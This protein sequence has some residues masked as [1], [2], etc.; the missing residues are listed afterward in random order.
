MLLWLWGRP[1]AVALIGPLAW[2]P[3]WAADA[4]L[5]SKR[6][7]PKLLTFWRE[8]TWTGLSLGDVLMEGFIR[9][10]PNLPPQADWGRSPGQELQVSPSHAL[11]HRIPA[12][13]TKGGPGYRTDSSG[14]VTNRQ[15][16]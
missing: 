8:H 5:E 15:A 3:P 6:K 4:P 2:E 11:L 12:K 13:D 1:A 14:R 7:K 16:V 9:Q 10:N